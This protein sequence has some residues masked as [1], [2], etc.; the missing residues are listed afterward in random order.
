MLN[1]EAIQAILPHRPPF[2]FLDRIEDVVYGQSATGIIEDAGQYGYLLSGHFPGYP[3]FPGAL[4]VEALAEV[5]A[6]AALGLET[7]Q[8]KLAVL[9]GLDNWRFRRPAL[10]GHVLRLEVRLTAVRG[11]FGRG[12]GRATAEGDLL[13][14]GDISFA[15]I[16][17]PAEWAATDQ[18]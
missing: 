15:I 10:P 11:N 6:V 9:T 3:I 7:N 8:G 2:L 17:R 4:L 16:P 5:G 18:R 1:Q 14:E 12:H 13:A